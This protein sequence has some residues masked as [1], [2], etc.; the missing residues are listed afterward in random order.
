MRQ[1]MGASW[2]ESC[3]STNVAANASKL[4]CSLG[5]D[6]QEKADELFSCLIVGDHISKVQ[7]ESGDSVH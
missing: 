6:R 4:S 3:Q 2:I 1:V 7:T 5:L